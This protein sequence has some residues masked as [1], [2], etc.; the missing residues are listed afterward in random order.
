MNMIIP[1]E[2]NV[3]LHMHSNASDGKLTPSELILRAEKNNVEMLALTDHDSLKGITEAK[4]SAQGKNIHFIPG[5]EI[6]VTW[7]SETIHVLGLNIDPTNEILSSA[8]HSIQDTRY[9]R[10]KAINQALV[11]AGL[12]SLLDEALEEAQNPGQISRT[13]FARVMKSKGICASMQDVFRNYLVSGK[14]G[15][16]EHKWVSLKSAIEWIQTAEGLA[17]LAHPAR[18][19]LSAIHLNALL[20]DFSNLGGIAIEVATGSHS[21]SD[22]KKFQTIANQNN[23]EAS[24]GSDFHSLTESRFDVGEAPPLP[25]DT[26]PVWARWL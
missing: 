9:K 15:F 3:D 7:G 11:V 18:Y 24:R 13:H 12:P 2:M 14:P 4:D 19:K 21:Y 26:V 5:V 22:I 16:V 10:A 6:S 20:D 1:H 25:Y 8:L 17:V 23:F